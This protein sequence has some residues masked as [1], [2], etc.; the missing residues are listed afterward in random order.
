MGLLNEETPIFDEVRMEFDFNVEV[1][2]AYEAT[3]HEAML[4]DS[5]RLVEN[6]R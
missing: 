6:K 5:Y 3:S 4:G 1:S 2:L